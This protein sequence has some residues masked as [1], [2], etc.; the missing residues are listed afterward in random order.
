MAACGGGGGGGSPASGNSGNNAPTP[1]ETYTVG[2]SVTNLVGPGLVIQNNG[3]DDTEVT[4]VTFQF[5]SELESGASY[6][7]TIANQPEGQQCLVTQASGSVS[8]ANVNDIDITCEDKDSA[9]IVESLDEY[10]ARYPQVAVAPDGSAIVVWHYD[11]PWANYYIPGTGWQTEQAIGTSGNTDLLQIGM[12]SNGNGIAVWRENTEL[13]NVTHYDLK[14]AY[15]SPTS[16]WSPPTLIENLED[17]TLTDLRLAVSDNGSATV[18]WLVDDFWQTAINVWGNTFQPGSGW[19]EAQL[20]ETF[21]EPTGGGQAT[22]GH[23]VVAMDPFGNALALW[24]QYTGG[25]IRI[26]SNRYTESQGWNGP[27]AINGQDN[28]P[29]YVAAGNPNLGI[30]ANGNAIAVWYNTDFVESNYQFAQ[31]DGANGWQ[32]EQTA[33]SNE[34]ALISAPLLSV[35]SQ[36]DALLTYSR[37]N[38]GVT[39]FFAR[40]WQG[41]QW[42]DAHKFAEDTGQNVWWFDTSVD[43]SGNAIIVW[44]SQ[45]RSD[46]PENILAQVYLAD[47]GWQIPTIIDALERE[48]GYEAHYPDISIAANGKGMAVWIQDGNVWSRPVQ[49]AQ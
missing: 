21:D 2:G 36:G 3:A 48:T 10:A 9:L 22:A 17:D 37:D 42:S 19:S 31:F 25:Q 1:V 7:V 49:L 6:E 20:L 30:D 47:D 8:N 40:N 26:F 18:V 41:N 32:P 14:A 11:G 15:F 27:K 4:S 24:D 12:D 45:R 5:A 16:G 39:E 46:S 43:E 13:N 29:Q 35:G 38:N 44:A 33:T 28:A 34:N 23:P